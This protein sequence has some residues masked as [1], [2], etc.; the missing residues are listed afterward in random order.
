M[1][2][3]ILSFLVGISLVS[4]MG[5]DKKEKIVSGPQVKELDRII[6][7][8]LSEKMNKQTMKT[9]IGPMWQR[10]FKNGYMP[11][12]KHKAND[13]VYGLYT[14]YDMKK[15]T[16]TTLVGCFVTKT[17]DLS[18]GL[19]ARTFPASKYAM[20]TTK[21]GPMIEMCKKGWEHIYNIWMKKNKEKARYTADF[22]EYEATADLKSAVVKIYISIK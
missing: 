5:C 14:D 10:F 17:N 12:I 15:G 20:F 18:K 8:G 4:F 21:K 6:F 11:Q 3:Y 1:K 9:K 7:V 16:F 13:K 2:F 22:E 19:V